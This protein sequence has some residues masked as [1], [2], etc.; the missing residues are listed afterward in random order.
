MRV[1]VATEL[2]SGIGKRFA[3]SGELMTEMSRDE[4]SPLHMMALQRLDDGVGGG[5][6]PISI[7][8][9]SDSFHFRIA[10]LDL[11]STTL[12]IGKA[13]FLDLFCG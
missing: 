1:R 12:P 7:K 2:H 5:G 3:L 11:L 9:Y 4:K 6:V 8:G 10:A 13:V